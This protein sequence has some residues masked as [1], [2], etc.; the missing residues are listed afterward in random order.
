MIAGRPT[1]SSAAARHPL[2]RALRPGGLVLEA[3]QDV[4]LAYLRRDAG[5]YLPLW[6]MATAPVESCGRRADALGRRRGRR[7]RRRSWAA[8]PCPA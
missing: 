7:V 6:Q 5:E 3:L 1:W 4:A 2:A 8:A